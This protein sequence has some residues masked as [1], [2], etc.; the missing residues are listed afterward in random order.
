MV[1][2]RVIFGVPGGHEEG[3][4][5]QQATSVFNV[6]YYGDWNGKHLKH[7]CILSSNGKFMCFRKQCILI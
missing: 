1:V 6:K 3:H 5:E 2:P 4:P 7:N